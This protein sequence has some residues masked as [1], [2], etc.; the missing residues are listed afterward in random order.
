MRPEKA[1]IVSELSEALKR[2]PFVLVTDYRGM[3][4]ADFSELR[5]RLSP[6]RA[7][8]HVVKNSFLKLAMADSGFPEVGDQVAGQ[9]AVVTGEADVAPV[10]KIFKTFAIEFKLAALRVG[11]VDRAALSTT[12]LETLAE[13]P[14]REILQAQLLGVL[15]SPAARLVSLFNQPAAA[16]ARLLSAKAEKE[17]AP[18]A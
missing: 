11:F 4:V 9:T 2:S 10:A 12:E 3:K 15:L 17:G 16:L 13:L 1:N 7:A 5:H 8:V 6:A 18:A 14:A